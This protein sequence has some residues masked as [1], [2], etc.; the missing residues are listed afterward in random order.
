MICDTCKRELV[1]HKGSFSGWWHSHDVAENRRLYRE[2]AAK[3]QSRTHR[4]PMPENLDPSHIAYRDHEYDINDPR[5][6]GE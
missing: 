6:R 4:E 5:R 1:W 3:R 2:C